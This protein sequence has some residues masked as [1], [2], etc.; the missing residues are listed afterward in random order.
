M[1]NN[2]QVKKET[3]SL[4]S[5]LLETGFRLPVTEEEIQKYE[6]IFGNTDILLPKEIDSPDFLLHKQIGKVDEKRTETKV[7]SLD[8]KKNDYFKKLVLAAEI[9]SQL[10]SEPTFG[11]IKFVKINFLCEELCHM[12]LS[13]NYGKYA[14]GPLDP[15]HMH[16]VEAEFK[17]RKWFNV[18]KR[19]GGYGF[20]YVP[21]Q[22]ANDYKKYYLGYFK[23]EA[24]LIDHLI[25]LFRKKS[26]DFCEIVATMF[27]V[28]KNAN[29][30]NITID[31]NL[32]ITHFYEWGEKKKRFS[33]EDLLKAIDWMQNEQVIPSK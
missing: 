20:K 18:V 7:V 32:L 33:E 14:A 13:T 3:R 28:W 30:K 1:S 19:T 15:K 29:S 16:S 26:T 10:Y 21:G 25:D 23:N 9:V 17:K 8:S 2:N 27:F 12:K 4:E 5:I 11:H 31:N 24:S 22:N 6:E